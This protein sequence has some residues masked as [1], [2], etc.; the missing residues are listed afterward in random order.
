MIQCRFTHKHQTHHACMRTLVAI[1]LSITTFATHARA[2]ITTFEQDVT[3]LTRDP[4]RLAG[5]DHGRKA[6]DY[7][8]ER[9]RQMGI[10]HLHEQTMDVWTLSPQRCELLING[11]T[12]QLLPMR[13]NLVVPPV[14]PAQGITGKLLYAGNGELTDYAGRDPQGAI[15]VLE[16]DSGMNWRLALRLGAA[17]IVFLPT[18]SATP[19]NTPRHLELPVNLLRLY[20][21]PE[22]MRKIDLRKDYPQATIHSQLIWEKRQARNIIA[23]IAGS[24]KH[25]HDDR[26]QGEAIVVSANYDSFGHVPQR[27]PAAVDAANV[28]AVLQIAKSLEDQPTR[29][30]VIIAFMDAHAQN[31]LGARTFYHNMLRSRDQLQQDAEQHK[32]EQRFLEKLIQPDAVMQPEFLKSMSRQAEYLRED[33]NLRARTL[34]VNG[35]AKSQTYLDTLDRISRWDDIRRSLGRGSVT[36]MDDPLWETLIAKTRTIHQKRLDEL[37][38]LVTRDQ[39]A[40]AMRDDFQDPWIALHVTLSL[41]D[42]ASR[43]GVVGSDATMR[44][45][46]RSN[47]AADNPGFYTRILQGLRSAADNAS[48]LP[49]L[50]PQTLRDTNAGQQIA[51]YPL[52]TDGY[53]AGYSG[54]YNVAMVTAGD[55]RVRQ[56]HPNDVADKLVLKAIYE[57]AQE[58]TRLLAKTSDEPLLSQPRVFQSLA[59][60]KL[61]EWSDQRKEASGHFVSN[62]VTGG[63]REQRPAMQTMVAIWPVVSASNA[64]GAFERT[65]RLSHLMPFE[66]TMT[67][68]HGHYPLTWLRHDLHNN[69]AVMAI[70]FDEQGQV[71]GITNQ[72]SLV[73]SRT[74]PGRSD[75]FSARG[76]F[77][78]WPWLSQSSTGVQTLQSP[79]DAPLRD[80]MTL[81][82]QY[83]SAE[84]SFAY[85]PQMI[86]DR[87][88][89]KLVHPQGPMLL[90]TQSDEPLGTGFPS[91]ELMS[92][93]PVDMLTAEDLWQL[94]ESRLRLLRQR[95][96][97][98]AN[99]ESLHDEAGRQLREGKQSTQLE[100]HMGLLGQSIA[101]SR[102]VYNPI[103]S[104]MNDLVHAVVILLLLAIPFAFALERL[105]LG[106]SN[107]YR[108][109]AGFVSM[110]MATFVLLYWLHPGFAIASTPIIIFLAFT[111][112]LL[113]SLVIYI[114]TRKFHAELAT[115]QGYAKR[116]HAGG[117]SAAGT[118]M[119]AANMG[120]SSMRRRPLRTWLTA[121]TVVI[122]TFTILCFA[123]VSNELGIRQTYLGTSHVNN[124]E[125]IL[126]H[127]LDFSPVPPKVV[128]MVR[129]HVAVQST[130]TSAGT[131]IAQQW[132]LARQN[133]DYAFGVIRSGPASEQNPMVHV[134]GV[135]GL[136][137]R[138]LARW[139][140]MVRALGESQSSKDVA[141]QLANG[142]VYLPQV[143]AARL[144][145]QIGDAILLAGRPAIFAGTF[146]VDVMQRLNHLDGQAVLP[147]DFRDP[148]LLE[149]SKQSSRNSDNLNTMD[150]QRHFAR[151]N[152]SQVAIASDDLVRHAGGTLHVLK[153]YLP[154]H[155]EREEGQDEV[156]I[157]DALATELGLPLWVSNS[158]GVWRMMF[159][160]LTRISGDLELFVPLF[161]GGLIIFGTMLGSIAD[162]QKEIY[163]FSALGLAPAHVG[164]LFFV[165]AAV[166]AVV[167]GMGGQLLA[168][169]V[170]KAAMM[171][172]HAGWI[173]PP[174]INFSSSN[175]MF[176]IVVVMATVL[177]SAIYPAR[178]ASRSAN[179]GVARSWR[180][181]PPE[182]D[183]ARMTF[184]FTVSAHDITGVMSFLAEHLREHDDAG[185]GRLAVQWA[186][187]KQNGEAKHL[188]LE[189][190]MALAPF[191]LGISHVLSLKAVPSEIPGIDEVLVEA[192]RVSGSHGD[193]Q[194]SLRVFIADMRKQFLLWRTLSPGVM[195][196][197]RLKTLCELETPHATSVM[198]EPIE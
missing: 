161:L 72:A 152:P 198:K 19:D 50:L 38:E 153:V 18:E 162:R 40:I 53:V 91:V 179:P 168:Q 30:D 169:A 44:L 81:E 189:S 120:M 150:I 62:Q 37:H 99:L 11:Q 129:Q 115:M 196:Q 7:L 173:A 98:D 139:P 177:I 195:E 182:G 29:R 43:W 82:G 23:R 26:P 68:S 89:F 105:L 122:L 73:Q 185:L 160:T 172:A 175:A 33:L 101:R 164:L 109:L 22:S 192:R 151:L 159:T 52:L 92:P 194:R 56:G 79:G 130:Q 70:R 184:P 12:I 25:F 1:V 123:T 96:V 75:L 154:D 147:V 149:A 48:S 20:V 106:A 183:L 128:A 64:F 6:G 34:R 136:D 84:A 180:M 94:N 141:D 78:L 121:L 9:L 113:S 167:G 74:A 2:D 191:D 145:L 125:S 112:V 158:S 170:A 197:Y 69:F 90:N 133:H 46:N 188:V 146:D 8:L 119:V 156:A 77:V 140:A 49:G 35:D 134:E 13:A 155:A 3:A 76:M 85:A 193:W 36:Q 103:R 171:M 174:S 28:A 65:R 32:A 131:L 176:A 137:P 60:D 117:N 166:Y 135:M 163:T 45:I 104:V 88:R 187:I 124:Q 71:S 21:T 14:T 102:H 126:I 67:D 59:M 132:W 57:Q 138:E 144:R 178:R 51:A 80:T 127:Q 97:T 143:I 83:R 31:R 63:L 186:V 142:G 111:I 5:S 55:A 108:R 110:F 95:G 87:S 54:I 114:V 93:L 190:K 17:G 116:M 27:S 16:Y 4:H 86:L 157:A 58:V 41:S 107:I 39:A 42:A 24:D 61:P 100:E 181:P 148:E 15:V 165:E 10:T 47:N 118:L 66:L